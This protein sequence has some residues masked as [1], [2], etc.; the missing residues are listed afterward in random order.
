[1][2]AGWSVAHPQDTRHAPADGTS[3][4]EIVR[5]TVA[6][7]RTGTHTAGFLTRQRASHLRRMHELQ[8]QPPGRDPASRLAREHTLVR[9]TQ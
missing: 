2:P 3:T 4:E 8:Q 1:M 5:K 6:S 7:L 9:S